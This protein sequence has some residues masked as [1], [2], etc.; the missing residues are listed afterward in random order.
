MHSSPVIFN[1]DFGNEA[2][3]LDDVAKAQ[4]WARKSM[5]TRK[6]NEEKKNVAAEKL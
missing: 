5:E 1:D 3:R 4:E 6:A 2:A